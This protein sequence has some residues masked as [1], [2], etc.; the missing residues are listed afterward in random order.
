MQRMS[1]LKLCVIVLLAGAFM[2]AC[3][4]GRA[5][6][7]D[8]GPDPVNPPTGPGT[9]NPTGLVNT[10][11]LKNLTVPVTF[12][13]GNTA[14]A[15]CIYSNAPA[16][17]P[18]DAPG[19][20]FTCV[21]DVA[22]AVLVYCRNPAFATDTAIQHRAFNG[23]RF[24]INMQSDNG[25]FFNFLQQGNVIN[26][27]GATSINLAKWWSW[28][29]LQALT[30]GGAVIKTKN[31]TLSSQI[32]AAV[33]KLIS[34][35]QT[36]QVNLPQTS[37]V[38]NGI[39]IPQW[40]PEG[41]D[42]GATLVLGLIPYCQVSGDLVMKQYVKKLADGIIA[43]QQGDASHFP[44]SCFL[45][46]G[47]LWHAYGSDQAHAL[48][49][50]ARFLNDTSYSNRALAE[51]DNFYPWLFKN[52]LK[53]SFEVTKTGDLI[54]AQNVQDYEQIAYGIRPFVS[55]AVDAYVLTGNPKYADMAGK[56]I[57]WYFGR[58]PASAVMYDQGT[59]RCFDAIGVG[60]VVN[61]NAGAESC[62][63]ALLTMQYADASPAVLSALNKYK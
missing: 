20:G 55:A 42:A 1:L 8:G 32:D 27:N 54:T 5:N 19:E 36:D 12:P 60:N 62:I 51:V 40:L 10:T 46:S 59:G 47:T 56:L 63:E 21:D 9:G 57:S 38:Q 31:A 3:S 37:V 7:P 52:G 30:E 44:Y 13:N 24:V 50:V 17:T 28:R 48:F 33:A 53:Y 39:A 29:A 23:I 14:E 41:A 49:Q 26:T 34:R 2:G 22:R 61:R 6:G 45:S 15:I 43:M 25:Y 16:Y 18:A 4:K 58:N 35:L 11:H